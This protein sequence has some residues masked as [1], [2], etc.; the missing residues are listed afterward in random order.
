MTG[1]AQPNPSAAQP[2]PGSAQPNPSADWDRFVRETPLAS[3]LQRSEWARVKAVNGWRAARIV[4]PRDGD[5]ARGVPAIGAQVLL[6]KPRPMP[7]AFAYAPRGPVAT[8]WSADA[9]AGFTDAVRA[10]KIGRVS[11]LRVDPEI[12]ADG[13]LDPDGAL[14][15]AFEAA[16][17]QAA[18]PVQPTSTRVIDLRADEAALW[19]DLRK[20]WRQYVNKAR[21]SGVT[22]IEPDGDPIPPF[23]EIYR[24]TAPGWL[25]HP[26]RA[27]LPRHLERVP[28]ESRRDDALR[29]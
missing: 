28:P 10:A 15:R 6:R 17:W 5:A 20:K 23:Y 24:E 14:R 26:H 7:W 16:G 3:Y 4:S 11:H 18:P 25:P 13:P 27:G 9:I 8:E 1:S 2:N 19:G 21:T 22:V 12:E 29:G